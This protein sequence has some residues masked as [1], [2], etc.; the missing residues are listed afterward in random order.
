ML[1]MQ[2]AGIIPQ[3]F[4]VFLCSEYFIHLYTFLF[5]SLNLTEI[6]EIRHFGETAR[7]HWE[8]SLLQYP[9]FSR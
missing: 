3:A 2:D 1:I 7:K 5:S 6:L 9:A 4:L 8:V